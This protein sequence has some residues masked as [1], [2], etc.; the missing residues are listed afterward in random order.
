MSD[1]SKRVN[2]AGRT[3]EPVVKRERPFGR[4]DKAARDSQRRATS[5]GR[6]RGNA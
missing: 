5:R 1:K 2:G 6:A 4:Y 3:A